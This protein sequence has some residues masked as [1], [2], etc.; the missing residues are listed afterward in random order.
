MLPCRLL[1]AIRPS[2]TRSRNHPCSAHR[3]RRCP[4]NF[5]T[6]YV[7]MISPRTMFVAQVRCGAVRRPRVVALATQAAKGSRKAHA[8]QCRMRGRRAVGQARTGGA[9]KLVERPAAF[10]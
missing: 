3:R 7:T 6:G 10:A 1:C 2:G 4:Q 5:R 8:W 9:P